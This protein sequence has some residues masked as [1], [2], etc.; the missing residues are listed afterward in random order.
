MPASFTHFSIAD[1]VFQNASPSLQEKMQ[2]DLPL[3]YFGAQG[4]DFCFFYRTLPNV[5]PNL[6][7]HLHREGSFS[8]FLTLHS[9]SKRNP[10]ILAY[11]LGYITHYVADT[12]FHPFIY[13][14]G[15]ENPLRH[16]RL[17]SLLDLHVSK[18]IEKS[19]N[20]SLFKNKFTDEE[21]ELLFLLYCAIATKAQLSLPKK[22]PFLRAISLF[23]A[24]MPLPN[25]IFNTFTPNLLTQL[26]DADKLFQ[27]TV[28]RSLTLMETF[29]NDP[30]SKRVFGKNFLTGK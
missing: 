22:T 21:K 27:L 4:A 8:A 16:S 2:A 30:L 18:R 10:A 1:V 7:S 24:T 12:T 17:E 5:Q 28:K 11:A 9:L 15:G 29:L 20:L 19:P 6:G 23:N 13:A 14:S 25:L 26:F 3:Y